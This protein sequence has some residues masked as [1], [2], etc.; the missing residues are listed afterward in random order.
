MEGVVAQL[1]WSLH[2]AA[3][4]SR[5]CLPP[6]QGRG[7]GAVGA[8]M[9]LSMLWWVSAWELPRERKGG[10]RFSVTDWGEENHRVED[11]RA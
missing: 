3:G 11:Q 1:M 10:S 9:Q 7:A 2:A 6:W 5:R 4:R 8:L